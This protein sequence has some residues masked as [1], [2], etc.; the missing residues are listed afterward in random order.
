LTIDPNNKGCTPDGCWVGLK[1]SNDT[2]TSIKYSSGYIIDTF[3]GFM[4]YSENLDVRFN[5]QWYPNKNTNFVWKF[6]PDGSIATKDDS[7]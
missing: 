7:N 1:T 5:S 4:L 2:V 6:N 3:T